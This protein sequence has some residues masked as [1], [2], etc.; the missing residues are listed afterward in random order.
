MW[1]AP[2]ETGPPT[3]YLTFDDGPNPTATPALLDV[4][5]RERAHAT[6]FLID[7]HVTVRTAPIVRRMFAEGHGVAVHSHTRRLMWYSPAAMARWLDGA[8]DHLETMAGS[9]P[10]RAFRPHAGWRSATML[11]GVARADYQLIGWG[12]NAWD[13][14]WFRRPTAD[15]TVR[16]IEQRASNGLI[17]VMHDGHHVDPESER[18]R[19]VEAVAQLVPRLRT[20]GYAFGRICDVVP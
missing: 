8:A 13:W 19:T 4:L 20:R 1:R 9:R 6:F 14:N 18:T 11:A 12:W 15:S 7:R 10:C 5:A 16:R 3:I 17:V 2:V